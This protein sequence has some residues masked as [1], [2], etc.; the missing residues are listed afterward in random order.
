M[1]AEGEALRR[2]KIE[3]LKTIDE[4][5]TATNGGICYQHFV[6]GVERKLNADH[7]ARQKIGLSV[8]AEPDLAEI[9]TL[10]TEC[11]VAVSA[12]DSN[13]AGLRVSIPQ[14]E[15]APGD[16]SDSTTVHDFAVDEY[17]VGR[18]TEL[19]RADCHRP[20]VKHLQGVVKEKTVTDELLTFA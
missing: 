12:G 2:F 4:A 1:H 9:I 5:V 18:R 17:A 14:C 6:V 19:A 16:L 7:L 20:S 3:E 10:T 15:S 11:N 13:N 8:D